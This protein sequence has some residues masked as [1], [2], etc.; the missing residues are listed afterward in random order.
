[1]ILKRVAIFQIRF[2][3]FSSLYLRMSLPQNRCT[4]LRD[5]L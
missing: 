2:S 5:M 4:L 3:R 1:M